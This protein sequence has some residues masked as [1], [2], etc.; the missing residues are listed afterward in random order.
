MKQRSHSGLAAS[1]QTLHFFFFPSFIIVAEFFPGSF[2]DVYFKGRQ[3]GTLPVLWPGPKLQQVTPSAHSQPPAQPCW[4]L[5]LLSSPTPPARLHPQ[6]GSTWGPH[7]WKWCLI[8]QHP[9][10]LNS[11]PPAKAFIINPKPQG[12][13]GLYSI[14]PA[15]RG[16][17][18]NLQGLTIPQIPPLQVKQW[19]SSPCTA[20]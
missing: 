17:S 15:Y 8:H 2:S 14:S 10:V 11:L 9:H 19:S 18:A 6:H 13:I 16:F 3:A 1:L 12:A 7:P 20:T 5:L 4:S